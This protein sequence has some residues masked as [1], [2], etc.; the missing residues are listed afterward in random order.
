MSFHDPCWEL[1]GGGVGW[2]GEVLVACPSLCCTHLPWLR[3]HHFHLPVVTIWRLLAPWANRKE[4]VTVLVGFTGAPPNLA[5]L[6][7]IR[8]KS[9]HVIPAAGKAGGCYRQ[10]SNSR[11]LP[12]A[13]P[14]CNLTPDLCF[15]T[16]FSLQRACWVIWPWFCW[17]G[18][19]RS[20]AIA[21]HKSYC[22]NYYPEM[23]MWTECIE[24]NSTIV[25]IR[26]QPL[27][28]LCGWMIQTQDMPVERG[29]LCYFL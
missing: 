3:T 22:K 20:N 2:G 13:Q 21:L 24:V 18:W 14:G 1:G 15:R 11:S 4:Y 27:E 5:S 25:I 16:S 6:P 10:R 12:L 9:T 8:I 17:K 28:R 26:V 29:P 7:D 19:T 23:L